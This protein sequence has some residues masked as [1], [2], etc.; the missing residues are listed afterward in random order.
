ML[1]YGRATYIGVIQNADD[2]PKGLARYIEHIKAFVYKLA[3]LLEFLICQPLL[4]FS[5]LLFKALFVKE[6]SYALFGKWGTKLGTSKLFGGLTN[7][8]QS[9]RRDIFRTISNTR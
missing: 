4:Y 8:T 9:F 1:K 2:T 5:S 3:A 7:V 6:V